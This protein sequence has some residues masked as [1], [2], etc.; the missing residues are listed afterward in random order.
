MEKINI[1]LLKTSKS[2]A[3]ALFETAKKQQIEDSV[4]T[5]INFIAKTIE[6]NSNLSSFL[7]NPII[8]IEDK[9]SV[10][11]EI[12][13]NKISNITQNFLLLLADNSRYGVI[14]DIQREYKELINRNK[15]IIFVKAVS[16][17]EIKDYLKEKLKRKIESIIDKNAEIS[18]EINPDI[19]GGLVIEIDGKTID[20]SVQ[21]Q[22]KNI[23]KQLI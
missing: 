1:K 16:A 4:L 21:T 5:D 20:N 19:I 14:Y 22:L 2:Y 11:T 13:G 23:K 18:Y 17:I 7:N 3:S 8:K 6:E 9:K 15:N 12:F 10:M